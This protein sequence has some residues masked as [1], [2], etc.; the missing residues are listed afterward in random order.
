M[1]KLSLSCLLLFLDLK[2][3]KFLAVF[4]RVYLLRSLYF[5]SFSILFFLKKLSWKNFS[6]NGNYFE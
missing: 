1:C 2:A 5:F 6:G 3:F 4:F